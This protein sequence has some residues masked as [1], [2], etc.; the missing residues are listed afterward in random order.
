MAMRSHNLPCERL[1]NDFREVDEAIFQGVEMPCEIIFWIPWI[2][3][4]YFDGH[5]SDV[6]RRRLALRTHIHPSERLKKRLW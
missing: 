3:K 5:L 1:K 6:L 4:S 2:E